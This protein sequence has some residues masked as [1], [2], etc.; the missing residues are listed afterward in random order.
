MK[1]IMGEEIAEKFIATERVV[2][3]SGIDDSMG[4]CVRVILVREHAF[5]A[6]GKVE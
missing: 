3:D 5:E 4:V 2:C 6:G 1:T